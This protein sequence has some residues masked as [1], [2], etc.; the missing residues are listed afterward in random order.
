MPGQIKRMIDS[1]VTERAKGNT[2]L[3]TLTKTKL[4]L[5]GLDPDLYTATSPDD[6][7]TVAKV[8]SIAAEMGVRL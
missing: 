1:I 6:R 4:L 8:R 5:R 2:T 7:E 3:A